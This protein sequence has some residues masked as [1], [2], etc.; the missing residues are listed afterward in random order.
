M[1]EN[2]GDPFPYLSMGSSNPLNL[3]K[4]K[5]RKK[6]NILISLIEQIR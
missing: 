3:Q 5:E 4:E 2:G 6:H 1:K